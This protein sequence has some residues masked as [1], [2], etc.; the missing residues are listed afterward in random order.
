MITVGSDGTVAINDTIT[1]SSAN[2]VDANGNLAA[3]DIVF[4]VPTPSTGPTAASSNPVSVSD[5]GSGNDGAYGEGDTITVNFSTDV[6]IANLDLAQFSVAGKTLGTGAT[7][8]A[9]NGD[10][11][12][13]SSFTITLGAGTDVT[14][15]DQVSVVAA[16]VVDTNGR[17]G[18]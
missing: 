6:V 7:V 3:G 13:A 17:R 16:S 15:S 8:V 2:V 4:T 12:H 5:V 18:C 1:L 9:A 14:A 11:T 10:G